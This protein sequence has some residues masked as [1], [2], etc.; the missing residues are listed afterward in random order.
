MAEL[1]RNSRNGQGG[2]NSDN[3][4]ALSFPGAKAQL[5]DNH[6]LH[7]NK[8][9]P[10]QE[11][12][13][14]QQYPCPAL[15]KLWVKVGPHRSHCPKTIAAYPPLRK[16]PYPNPEPAFVPRTHLISVFAEP[17]QTIH[18]GRTNDRTHYSKDEQKLYSLV[19]SALGA[20]NNETAS[21]WWNKVHMA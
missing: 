13:Y 2:A 6:Y 20:T 11:A 19:K 14:S 8:H 5:I 7:Q 17:P 3:P 9:K 4:K 21:I 10:N 16:L 15:Y 18:D 12:S 1:W